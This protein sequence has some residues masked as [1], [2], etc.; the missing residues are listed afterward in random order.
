MRI[1]GLI[2]LGSAAI[3]ALGAAL[4]AVKSI[5]DIRTYRRIRNM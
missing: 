3:A 1:I 2:T 4:V 5:P